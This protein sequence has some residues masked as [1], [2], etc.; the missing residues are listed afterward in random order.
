[1]LA[2]DKLIERIEGLGWTVTIEDEE[3]D[4]YLIGQCTPESQDF[5]ISIEIKEDLSNFSDNLYDYWSSYD[6]SY[7]S[8][9]RIKDGHGINGAP[10]EMIDVYNDFKWCKDEIYNLW[11]YLDDFIDENKIRQNKKEFYQLIVKKYNLNSE[12]MILIRNTLNYAQFHYHDFSEQQEFL[13]NLLDNIIDND[14]IEN[15]WIRDR[16]RRV[17]E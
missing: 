11:T 1:M 15:V 10:Y 7:E 9:L 4:L 8:S 16:T 17:V 2:R 13:S 14:D 12:T 3:R 6:V 5:S